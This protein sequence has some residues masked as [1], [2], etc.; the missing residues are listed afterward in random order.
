MN[1]EIRNVLEGFEALERQA[2]KLNGLYNLE[3][4]SMGVDCDKGKLEG[5]NKAIDENDS[6]VRVQTELFAKLIGVSYEEAF[7]I[8]NDYLFDKEAR[9]EIVR[10]Y[11]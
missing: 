11:C 4:T 9:T 2:Q 1:K 7:A 8:S 5:I 3:I 6:A 10:R